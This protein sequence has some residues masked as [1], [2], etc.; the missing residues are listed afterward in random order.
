[1]TLLYKINKLCCILCHFGQS[2]SK[3]HCETN[4]WC[5]GSRPRM[6]ERNITKKVPAVKKGSFLAELQ[7]ETSWRFYTKPQDFQ[8][9]SSLILVACT[10][11]HFKNLTELKTCIAYCILSQFKRLSVSGSVVANTSADVSWSQRG[12]SAVSG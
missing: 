2:G 8:V 12:G 10:L 3:N 1:M 6:K 4:E 11:R 9:Q 5:F 7:S